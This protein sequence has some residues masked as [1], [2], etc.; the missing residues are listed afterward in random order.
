M[1]LLENHPPRPR[2]CCWRRCLWGFSML[3]YKL[4]SINQRALIKFSHSLISFVVSDNIS[5]LFLSRSVQ[6]MNKDISY[7]CVKF[8]FHLNS[9]FKKYFPF[10]NPVL[11]HPPNTQKSILKHCETREHSLKKFSNKFPLIFHFQSSDFSE[12]HLGYGRMEI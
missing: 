8:V 10:V 3:K 9:K 1:F 2:S 12:R 6:I 5:F 7:F 4:I 11:H